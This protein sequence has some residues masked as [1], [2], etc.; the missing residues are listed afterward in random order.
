MNKEVYIIGAGGHAKVIAN[1]IYKSGD[2]VKGFL[3]DNVP[4]ETI[5]IREKELKV[6]G[7]IA[8][9]ANLK[10]KYPEAE[11]IL[12]VGNNFTRKRICDQLGDK[13]K[14]YT[15]I[16]QSSQIALDVEIGKGTVILANAC[17]NTNAKIGKHCIINTGAIVEHDNILEDY[18]H[19]SPNATL[20]GTVKIGEF[21]HI[22][23]GVTVKNNINICNNCIIGIGATVVKDIEEP[24]VYVGVPSKRIK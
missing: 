3:D 18:V 21:T 10:L 16:D 14:Y 24:G 6:I 13:I 4:I 7:T 15:A 2:I 1:V 23:S 22:G 20:S 12:G 5:I 9:I 17:I 8:D 19:I 11:F